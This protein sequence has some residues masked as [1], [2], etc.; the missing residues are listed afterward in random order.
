MIGH[1]ISTTVSIPNSPSQ[2][3]YDLDV[4][5]MSNRFKKA[6]D[7]EDGPFSKFEQRI[8]GWKYDTIL[9]HNDVMI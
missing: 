6:T 2:E 7:N 3:E 4:M 5:I 8:Q 1:Q 9:S